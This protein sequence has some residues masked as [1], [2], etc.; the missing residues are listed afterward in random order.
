MVTYRKALPSEIPDVLDFINMVFSMA[1]SPHDFRHMLPKLYAE[2]NEDK[3]QHYIAV[4]NGKIKGCVCALSVT[5]RHRSSSLTCGT[6]GSVSVHPY[7]RGKG[8]MRQLMAMAIADMKA[9]HIAF[10]SLSG[11]RNRYQYYG[12]EKG[13][14]YYNYRFIAHNFRHRDLLSPNH[15]IQLVKV[16]EPQNPYLPQMC[17]LSNQQSV[18]CLRSEKEF[19]SILTSWKSELYA[20]LEGDAFRGYV[21]LC[22]RNIY[23]LNMTDVS[24]L[25]PALDA[26]LQKIGGNDLFLRVLPHQQ[27]LIDAVSG[28]YESFSIGIDDN[29]Q[30]FN[31]QEVLQFYL[32]IQAEIRR[33]PDGVL[34]FT[35]RDDGSYR[36]SVRAGIPTVSRLD[37]PASPEI[38]GTELISLLFSPEV[39]MRQNKPFGSCSWFPL[40]LALCPLDKC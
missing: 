29:Y 12:Y 35:I 1:H 16:S 11:R 18:C 39:S 10:S 26:C 33:L 13:G 17:A 36:I 37:H 28:L 25:F 21:S 38:T 8:Y 3:S 30:I 32:D 15:A 2:G 14:F 31:Y 9:D 27:D 7:D 23:E 24:L 5:I 4:E 6:I 34:D 19:L 20:V 22:G 40:P